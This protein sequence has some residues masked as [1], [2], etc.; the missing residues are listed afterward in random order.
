MGSA[1]IATHIFFD[2]SLHSFAYALNTNSYKCH[3]RA[4]DKS[5]FYGW[6]L[7][8]AKPYI[9]NL[10]NGLY[11]LLW[12]L[13]SGQI[14]YT[15]FRSTCLWHNRSISPKI[16]ADFGISDHSSWTIRFYEVNS[17]QYSAKGPTWG[18]RQI[19]LFLTSK[20]DPSRKK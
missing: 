5:K 15:W 6:K 19:N 8:L 2:K 1:K 12:V 4:Q 7:F 3:G 13:G 17:H 18:N 9:C 11:G 14:V 20:V 10:M 16:E